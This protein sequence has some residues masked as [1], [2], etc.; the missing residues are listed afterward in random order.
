VGAFLLIAALLLSGF[1]RAEPVLQVR[2]PNLD[3]LEAKAYGYRVLNLAL[4]KSGVDFELSLH[5]LSVNQERARILLEQGEVDVVDFGTSPEFEQRFLPVYFPID[6][7]LNGYRL[8]V[9]HK[10]N[11]GE[12]ARMRSITQLWGKTAGQGVR[13]SD[14]AILD[15]AGIKVATAS[16]DGLFRLLERK[17]IDF[18][19]LGANEVHL[20]LDKYHDAAPHAVVDSNLL[21]IY[22]FGRLFFVQK[23]NERLREAIFKGLEAAFDDGSFQALLGE[24]YFSSSDLAA[25]SQRTILRLENPSLTPEFRRIPHKYF[26]H[27]ER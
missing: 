26:Y 17:R 23:G 11:A 20:L 24:Y 14:I 13:W 22:P 16:I 3:S 19:P 4:Q 7:G 21:I 12:Y 27:L 5:P 15:R 1:V 9:V 2:Y 10:D 8:L 18:V 25:L 6:R